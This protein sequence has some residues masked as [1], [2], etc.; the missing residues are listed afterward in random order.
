[1]ID[2]FIKNCKINKERNAFL[3]G[4]KRITYGKLLNDIYK[5]VNLLKDNNFKKGEKILLFLPPSYEFY[6]LIFSCVY[7]GINVVVP[8]SFKDKEKIKNIVNDLNVKGVFCNNLTRVLKFSFPRSL[9]VCN[10]SRFVNYSCDKTEPDRD[11]FSTVLT[12]F[13]SGTTGEPKAI[14]RNVDFLKKQIE[15]ITASFKIADAEV[16]ASSL[17]VYVLF[18]IYGGFT[19]LLDGPKKKVFER[20]KV[21]CV[22]LPIISILKAKDVFFNV[23]RLYLGGA[24]IY[25]SEAEQIKN[26]FPNAEITYIYGASEC[27][28]IAYGNLDYYLEN[29]YAIKNIPSD[30]HI[31]IN[32][33]DKNG[34]GQISVEGETVLSDEGQY[35]SSDLGILEDRGLCIVG[36]KKFSSTDKYNY[37]IDE[38][39]LS[40]NQ[41]VKRGFSFVIENKIYF[42]YQGEIEKKEEGISYFKFRRLPMD[43][44]HKTKLDYNKTIKALKKRGVNF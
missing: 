2:N 20:A 38:R 6:L 41:K 4:N 32:C 26:K 12:T 25:H 7:C 1:M 28:L 5:M 36:R 13:T 29:G 10:V 9:K 33:G 16:V 22:I 24:R 39:I 23:K 35:C 37:L 31:S 11:R 42:C 3:I 15:S 21:D 34:V 27:A 44:K 19:V 40:Q 14:E 18:L 17:P 30:L 43:P 8:D